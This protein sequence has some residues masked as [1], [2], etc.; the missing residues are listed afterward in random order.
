MRIMLRGW[1]LCNRRAEQNNRHVTGTTGTQTLPDAL[2]S[3]ERG[4]ARISILKHALT[5]GEK[6]DENERKDSSEKK[7]IEEDEEFPD[8]LVVFPGG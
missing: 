1:A 5:P 3:L 8:L 6:A 7:W 2:E 4:N